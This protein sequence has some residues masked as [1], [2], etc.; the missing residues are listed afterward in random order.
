MASGGQGDFF[1]ILLVVGL[2]NSGKT[3]LIESYKQEMNAEKIILPTAGIGVGFIPYNSKKIVYYDMS[4]DGRHRY[5]WFN[6]FGEIHAILF[7]VDGGD[8]SR[9]PIVKDYIK[10]LFKDEIL[11]KREIPI[12]IAC[13]K[14]DVP[15][16][17]DKVGLE[18]DLMISHIERLPQIKY[19]VIN[20]SGY[21]NKGM[22]EG[23]DWLS[24]NINVGKKKGGK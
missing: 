2:D 5:Q 18:E 22:K 11:N 16:T 6:Y 7:V 21:E 13:N 17:R 8:V 15:D 10:S 24:K 14:Q 4:G 9:T 23:L 19:Y 1:Y 20:T 12:L 3:T